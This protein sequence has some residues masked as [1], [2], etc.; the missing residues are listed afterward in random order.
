[1]VD[2]KNGMHSPVNMTKL[3]PA[4]ANK[5][6]PVFTNQLSTWWERGQQI[7]LFL[8]IRVDDFHV[9]RLP[10]Q[11]ERFNSSRILSP[12]SN[13]VCSETSGFLSRYIT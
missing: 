1:M 12:V 9:T 3:I 4:A 6:R 13:M 7:I 2:Q 10:T 8:V 11:R 5:P